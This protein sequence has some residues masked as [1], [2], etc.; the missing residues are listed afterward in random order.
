MEKREAAA[1]MKQPALAPAPAG[2]AT[3]QPVA[4]AAAA[5]ASVLAQAA[6][7]LQ[8]QQAAAAAA[9]AQFQVEQKK[10]APA[11][12]AAAQSAVVP[13]VPPQVE[14]SVEEN[15]SAGA[16]EQPARK[17]MPGQAKAHQPLHKE[18]SGEFG[19]LA[20][21]F[22]PCKLL[23][24]SHFSS[25]RSGTSATCRSCGRSGLGAAAPA[26]GTRRTHVVRLARQDGTISGGGFHHP[27][28]RHRQS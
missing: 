5:E 19:E 20:V 10:E 8:K 9:Q 26:G 7:T 3:Q 4:A 11:T 21:L 14:K 17:P 1:N 16:V 25:A 18:I 12:A 28:G 6:E 27:R 15:G 2:M 22:V 13:V 23:D 24:I